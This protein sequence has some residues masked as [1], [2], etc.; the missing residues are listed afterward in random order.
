MQLIAEVLMI[1]FRGDD[2]LD[3]PFFLEISVPPPWLWRWT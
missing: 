2:K 1:E 3:F